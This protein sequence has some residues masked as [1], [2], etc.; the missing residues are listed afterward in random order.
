[1]SKNTGRK[2]KG[3]EDSEVKAASELELLQDF[4]RIQSWIIE[5]N[6]S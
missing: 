5:I 1:M 6:G 4:W 3:E 2:K